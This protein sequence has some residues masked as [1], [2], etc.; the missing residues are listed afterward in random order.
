MQKKSRLP[1]REGGLLCAGLYSP[2]VCRVFVALN[3]E[4][5]RTAYNDQE[6]KENQNH[7]GRRESTAVSCHC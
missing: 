1:D 4:N 6:D 5:P 3:A 7:P 2:N